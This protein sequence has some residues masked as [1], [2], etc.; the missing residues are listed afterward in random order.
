LSPCRENRKR[1]RSGIEPVNRWR[2]KRG[3]GAAAG[4]ARWRTG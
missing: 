3:C 4:R 2:R 1:W